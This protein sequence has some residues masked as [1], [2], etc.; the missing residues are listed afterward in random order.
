MLEGFGGRVTVTQNRCKKER[1]FLEITINGVSQQGRLAQKPTLC[2]CV[3]LGGL[4]YTRYPLKNYFL[5]I[6][7][8][9]LPEV[10]VKPSLSLPEHDLAAHFVAT[11][12]EIVVISYTPMRKIIAA[13]SM[14]SIERHILIWMQLLT[15]FSI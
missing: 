8:A 13:W 11:R 6:S 7:M 5:Y 9:L 2:V 15:C 4:N 3:C 10:Q 14:E 1:W 12:L